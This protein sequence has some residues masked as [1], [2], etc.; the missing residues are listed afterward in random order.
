MRKQLY[1]LSFLLMPFL[2]MAQ[3]YSNRDKSLIASR[4]DTLV[5]KFMMKSLLAEPGANKQ[6]LKVIREFKSLFAEGAIIFD[7]INAEYNDDGNGYPYKLK[8]KSRNVYF[9]EL[10]EQFPQ[11]LAINNK[12]VNISYETMDQ[13]YVQVALERNI[14]AVRATGK[15]NLFNEDTLLIKVNVQADKNVKITGIKSLG[16]NLRVLND[17]DLDGLIDPLDE[18]KDEKGKILL[19]GCPDRDDDGIPDK[20][21]DC[22]DQAGAASNKGCPQS[23]FAYQFVFSGSVGATLNFNSF[24]KTK[25]AELPYNQEIL[26]RS[27]TVVSIQNPSLQPG[28]NLSANIAYYYGKKKF[29]RNKGISLGFMFTRYSATYD[30]SGSKMVFRAFQDSTRNPAGYRRILSLNNFKEKTNFTTLNFQLMYRIKTK[31]GSKL[32]GEI[33]FGPSFNVITAKTSIPTKEVFV[34]GYQQY[35]ENGNQVYNVDAGPAVSDVPII[36]ESIEQ[37]PIGNPQAKLL[38]NNLHERSGLYDFGDGFFVPKALDNT[39]IRTGISINANAD[40]FYHVA[41]KVAI[42]AGFVFVYAPDAFGITGKGAKLD[43]DDPTPDTYNTIFNSGSAKQ[44]TAFGLNV[45]LIIGI[46][47]SKKN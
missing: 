47:T 24:T 21:D 14:S 4:I 20:S 26:D 43:K 10:I 19:K 38:F 36:K 35:D 37:Q 18:C 34:E 16:S 28:L 41:P 46:R 27:R 12:K 39:I 3:P 42:K 1:F 17:M 40:L 33:G 45:G 13:G 8:E 6:S 5:Q 9:D 31:F 15:Y 22:P 11:G 2:T 30:M 29:S 25:A 23:T 7:D 44:Y 32:A